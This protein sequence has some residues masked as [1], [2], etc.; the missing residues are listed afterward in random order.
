MNFAQLISDVLSVITISFCLF[1]KVPQI[2]S[3]IKLK[4]AK[5]INIYG[6]AM[7]LMSY[8][9]TA[10]Y[11]FIN[12]YA[13]LS[14]LEYPIIIVQEYVLI[15]LVLYYQDL[16]QRKT[17]IFALIYGLVFL[18]FLVKVLPSGVVTLILPLCTPISLSS[19]AVQL[20]E[21][22]KHMNADSVSVT[23]WV[24]SA[25]TNA[26]RIYTVLMDSADLILLSNLTLSTIMSGSIALIS[27]VLQNRSKARKE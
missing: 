1:L 12:G 14:Y 26:S 3:I 7:E 17:A 15:F 4:S 19:K 6:L 18:G 9:T 10:T 11:N 2:K 20:W 16:L 21:I 27:Y 5:G 24:I 22:L 13:L 8:S 25:L 23:S